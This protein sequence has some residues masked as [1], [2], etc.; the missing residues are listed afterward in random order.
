MKAWKIAAL[1]LAAGFLGGFFG[2]YTDNFLHK[3]FVPEPDV[4]I[5]L[6]GNNGS[7][8]DTF[9]RKEKFEKVVRDDSYWSSKVGFSYTFS[10]TKRFSSS[11]S[12]L[13]PD[14]FGTEYAFEVDDLFDFCEKL[15]ISYY[16]GERIDSPYVSVKDHNHDGTPDSVM[17]FDMINNTQISI[18]RN[19]EGI[20][21]YENVDE[22]GARQLFDYY[23]IEFTNFKKKHGID[24]LIEKYAQKF[25]IWQVGVGGLE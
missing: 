22:E 12:G 19:S 20:L 1:G 25:E 16:A 13:F 11:P 18:K 3:S 14:I 8:P 9:S 4:S 7:I 10:D 2:R 21:E 23:S 17:L 5:V 15:T 24:E 6:L